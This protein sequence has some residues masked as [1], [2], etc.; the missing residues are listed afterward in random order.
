MMGVQSK[1]TNSKCA[2]KQMNCHTSHSSQRLPHMPF[3]SKRTLLHTRRCTGHACLR[4]YFEQNRPCRQLPPQRSVCRLRS[5]RPDISVHLQQ[6]HHHKQPGNYP[7]LLDT[8]ES[9]QHAAGRTMHL[10]IR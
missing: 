10:Q 1:Q 4:Q 6:S 9:A 7:R 8:L 3:H 2:S 5:C